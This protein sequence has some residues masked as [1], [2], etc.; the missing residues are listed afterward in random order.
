MHCMPDGRKP[1]VYWSPVVA[2]ADVPALPPSLGYILG[3]RAQIINAMGM[4]LCRERTAT[5][6]EPLPIEGPE[7]FAVDGFHANALGYRHWAEHIAR[8]IQ[9]ETPAPS[10]SQ[11][12]NKRDFP[13][14][15]APFE[16]GKTERLDQMQ[17]H[18]HENQ[19]KQDFVDIHSA[20]FT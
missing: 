3:L 20:F 8:I 11:N 2:M 7:G 15:A 17:C 4:Q 1:G 5:T 10:S 12:Q 14:I 6:L 16:A 9:A 18:G 13:H 19:D